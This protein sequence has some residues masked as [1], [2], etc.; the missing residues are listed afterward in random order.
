MYNVNF[1]ISL[2]RYL[3]KM[4]VDKW[5]FKCYNRYIKSDDRKQVVGASFSQRAAG[6]CEA[7]EV[8]PMNTFRELWPEIKVG[9]NGGRPL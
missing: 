2:V 6:W 1:T 5:I 7:E 8:T 4:T 9:F 3:C